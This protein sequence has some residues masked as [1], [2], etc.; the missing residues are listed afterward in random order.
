MSAFRWIL[1]R[2]AAAAARVAARVRAW[3]RLMVLGAASILALPAGAAGV[4]GLWI[5]ASGDYAVFMQ[6]AT[7]GVTFGFQVPANMSSL[8]VWMGSGSASSV[9]LRSLVDGNDSL[10]ASYTASTMTGTSVVGG[11][12]KP[13][14]A[15]LALAWVATE[16]A[17]VWQ[18]STGPADYL[19]FCVLSSGGF[20]L[21]LQ[22]DVRVNADKSYQYAVYTGT[23]VDSQFA[24]VSAADPGVAS[25]LNFGAGTLSGQLVTSGRPPQTTSYSATQIVKLSQ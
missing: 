6:D 11:A 7:S 22:I 18:K 8:K 1:L 4:N 17:G 14:N 3:S 19:V 24:G 23:L 25:R 2:A 13:F 21:A 16:Y 12:A 15:N 20:R 5:A 10:S 9:D